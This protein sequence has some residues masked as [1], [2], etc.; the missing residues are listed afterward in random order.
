MGLGFLAPTLAANFYNKSLQWNHGKMEAVL[1]LKGVGGHYNS[2]QDHP[3][4]VP[5]R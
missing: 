2:F 1:N 3:E 5:I 4:L